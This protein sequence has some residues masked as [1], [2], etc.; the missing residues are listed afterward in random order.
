[1]KIISKLIAIQYEDIYKDLKEKMTEDLEPLGFKHVPQPQAGGIVFEKDEDGF[2]S[3]LVHGFR[4]EYRTDNI[5]EDWNHE[6]I[7]MLNEISDKLP[8]W[9][10]G[11]EQFYEKS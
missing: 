7:S 1:M 5:D 4:I 11:E 8:E 9:V 6:N 10:I 2:T 3:H